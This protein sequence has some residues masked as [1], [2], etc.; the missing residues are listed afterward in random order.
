MGRDRDYKTNCENPEEFQST[1]PV[2]GATK[3]LS[4]GWIYF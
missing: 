2:W 3:T 1:R 4:Y